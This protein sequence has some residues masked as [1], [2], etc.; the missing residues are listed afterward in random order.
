MT[1]ADTHGE[2]D[3]PPFLGHHWETPTQQFEAGKLG[4]WLFLAT[5]LLLFGGLFVAYAVFRHLN[6]EMFA[7]GSQYLD[8]KM[9]AINTVVLIVSSLT[10]AWA[11]RA[12]QTNRQGA[13]KILLAATFL[14]GAGFM[15]IKYFEYQHK[16]H[17]NLVPGVAFYETPEGHGEH[18]A[19]PV[20][21]EQ[22]GEETVGEAVAEGAEAPAEGD[23]EFIIPRSDITPAAEGPTGIAMLEDAAAHEASSHEPP[24]PRTDP[25]RPANLHL[26][27][28]LYF[29]M[30][31]LHGLHVLAGM[32][33]IAWLL[34]RA[35]RREFSSAYFTPVDLGGLYWHVVDLIWIFLFPLLYLI[36]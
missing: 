16:F 30:T 19:A 31:G 22:A 4:M 33:V 5:E 7:Y 20:E 34:V 35:T 17:L 11:V 10:M 15:T 1:A 27:F 25:N 23:G 24:D 8:T 13:L 26:F 12:A 21:D 14:G 18:A 29:C 2:H 28:G 6:E 32:A 3:H 9:G 36:A